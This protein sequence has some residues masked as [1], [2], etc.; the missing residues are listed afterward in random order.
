MSNWNTAA[1]TWLNGRACPISIIHEGAPVILWTPEDDISIEDAINRFTQE[2]G[3]D[4]YRDPVESLDD[5]YRTIRDLGRLIG[6]TESA[7]TMVAEVRKELA[8]V[9]ELVANRRRP[10]VFFTIRSASEL[11]N[12][13]TCGQGSFLAELIEIAGGMI[14]YKHRQGQCLL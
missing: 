9:A 13:L 2:R 1:L 3:I 12:I 10:R 7:E 6:E 8:S 4:I 14:F 5:L 11:A